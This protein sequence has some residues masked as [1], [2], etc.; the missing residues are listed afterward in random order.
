MDSFDSSGKLKQGECRASN[1][2]NTGLLPISRVKG[3]HY[4]EGAIGMRNALIEYMNSEEGSVS[5]H[6]GH[7]TSN[8]FTLT[9]FNTKL[10]KKKKMKRLN[11]LLKDF[12][13]FFLRLFC[14]D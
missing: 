1:V 14:V 2:D 9:F 13:H 10:Y 12:D 11:S 8:L 7:C 5:W 3:S 6:L 4:R